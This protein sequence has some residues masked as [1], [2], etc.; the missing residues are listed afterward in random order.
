MT[1]NIKQLL[2]ERRPNLS[3]SSLT[4]YCS[5]LK[6]LYKK[7]WVDDDDIH[8]KNFDNSDKV[9]HFLKD[10]EPSKRK[11]ILSSLVVLTGNESY[12][13]YMLSDIEK[14]TQLIK[15]QVKSPSQEKNWV[16]IDEV[17]EKFHELEDEAKLLYKKK[18]LT[19]TDFQQIQQMVILALLGGLFI[20]VRR[21]LDYTAMKKSGQINKE[22]DNYFDKKQF[23][24]NAYKTRR[25]YGQQTLPIPPPLKKIIDK[26]ASLMQ[27]TDYLLV[28]SNSAPLTSVKLNQRLCKIFAPKKTSVNLLRHS[29]LQS[30]Y[31]DQ[32]QKSNDIQKTMTAMGSSPAMLSTY[33]KHDD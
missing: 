6:N 11:T 20:P 5:I 1:S 12:R 7:I 10:I 3:D 9:L 25:A 22:K 2:K 19:M 32:I 31:G 24:F 13:K 17:R 14:Y 30:L 23:Y 18:N 8:L 33:V 27:H 4:T 21:S 15:S 29:Y 26:F 28:D 16:T